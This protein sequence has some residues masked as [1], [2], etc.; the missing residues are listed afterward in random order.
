MV[1]LPKMNQ[2]THIC[3]TSSA[4]TEDLYMMAKLSV[5]S[6]IE[7]DLANGWLMV[8]QLYNDLQ[9]RVYDVVGIVQ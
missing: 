5:R 7:G 8:S 1:Y 4:R 6:L 2:Q 3:L 9:T